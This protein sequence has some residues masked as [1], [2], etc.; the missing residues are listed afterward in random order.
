MIKPFLLLATKKKRNN[1]DRGCSVFDQF[2][3]NNTIMW[4]IFN[5]FSKLKSRFD[6]ILIMNRDNQDS[7]RR[8]KFTPT[9]S[10]FIQYGFK[11]T[12][13]NNIESD[14]RKDRMFRANFGCSS[15]TASIVWKLLCRYCMA[16][17]LLNATPF[18]FLWAL[19]FLKNYSSE[20][21]NASF[22]GVDENTWRLWTWRMVIE[23]HKLHSVVV[24]NFVKINTFFSISV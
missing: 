20:N 21:V 2:S 16:Q 14:N 9:P 6:N 5:R 23:I 15:K 22:A 1:I 4:C 17:F 3:F 12:G 19:Y 7:V 18:H 24:R 10:Q 11:L 8:G 13:R